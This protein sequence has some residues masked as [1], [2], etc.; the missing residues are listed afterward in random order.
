MSQNNTGKTVHEEITLLKKYD[1]KFFLKGKYV[2]AEQ[3]VF[4]KWLQKNG[5]A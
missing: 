1:M 4:S 5:A 3:T 2:G